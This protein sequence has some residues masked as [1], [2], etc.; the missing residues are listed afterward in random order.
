M[1]LVWN[2]WFVSSIV[3]HLGSHR[4]P[5]RHVHKGRHTR[6]IYVIIRYMSVLNLVYVSPSHIAVYLN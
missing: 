1:S 3:F 2:R 6:R 4:K 5:I